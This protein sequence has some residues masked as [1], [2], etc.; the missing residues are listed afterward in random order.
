ML[1]Y[2]AWNGISKDTALEC[3]IELEKIRIEAL[4][5]DFEKNY[6]GGHCKILGDVYYDLHRISSMVLNIQNFD[7]ESNTDS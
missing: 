1:N 4:K 2:H 5:Y 7:S 3:L 6:P